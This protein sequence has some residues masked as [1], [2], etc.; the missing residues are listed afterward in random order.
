MPCGQCG[1][2]QGRCGPKRGNDAGLGPPGAAAHQEVVIPS[3]SGEVFAA[4]RSRSRTPRRKALRSFAAREI[5]EKMSQPAVCVVE[6][7]HACPVE[8]TSV[9]SMDGKGR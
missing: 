8:S 7:F 2:V 9:T 5:K 1:H 6:K 4:A 3:A